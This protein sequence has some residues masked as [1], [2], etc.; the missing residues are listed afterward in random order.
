LIVKNSKYKVIVRAH[1]TALRVRSGM[2]PCEKVLP[3]PQTTDP[4]KKRSG[5]T[6]QSLA[7]RFGR[8]SA[9]D[10]GGLE[11]QRQNDKKK[12]WRQER[13]VI[14]SWDEA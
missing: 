10:W 4:P 6:F 3:P 9:D 5:K 11:Y 2:H 7:P 14:Q 13:S 8:L 1:H 12:R